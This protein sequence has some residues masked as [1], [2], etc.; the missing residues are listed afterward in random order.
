[1]GAWRDTPLAA[2][3]ELRLRLGLRRLRGRG[4]VPELV[5]KALSYLVL[6]PLGVVF[7]GLVGAGMYRAARSGRG[8]Q[9]DLPVSAVLFGVWQ[10]WTAV[11]MSL[12]EREGVDLRRF[13]V[14]PLAAGRVFTYGLVASVV[15]DP[16]ALFWCVLLA[17]AWGGAAVGRPGAWLLPLALALLLFAASVACSVVLLQEVSGRILRGKRTRE[18][19]IALLYVGL[20]MGGAAL[21]GLRGRIDL[22][23]AREVLG[24]VQWLA[25]PAA[26]GAGAARRLF[27]GEVA[28]ALPWLAG[29]A[30]AVAASGWAAY[31]LTLSAA[32]SG[33]AG[34]AASGS[35]GGAGWAGGWLPGLL[36]P[37]LEREVKHLARHPLPG[38]LLLVIPAMAGVVAWQAS[39]LI[40]AEAGEVLRALPLLGFALYTHLAT[41]VFWLNA[42][43]WD[44]GGARQHYLAPLDLGEVLAAK[45]L[46]TY[47]LAALLYLGCVLLTVALV[48]APPGWALLA[49]LALHAGVAPWL[50]GLG[51]LLSVLN[52]RVASATLQRSGNLPALSGLL[53]MAIV[54]GVAGLF[55]LPVLLAL[56]LDQAWILPGAWLALGA[57]GLALYRGTL[58]R[59]G[60]LLEARRELLLG[61]VTGDEA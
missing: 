18:V 52:P 36:G 27:S 28:A 40:P 57:A 58:P 4:G 42:F 23:R 43:G 21:A 37:L 9:V 17:G 53:G 11:A 24:L 46:A 59:M 14:Y 3:V 34:G 56:R 5:A 60:R 61:V 50:H 48:G 35:S 47:A 33:G 8:V 44:R 26:L 41:Q 32:T 19:A 29:Q 1:M 55:A 49:A 10:A 16:F 7:A 31:R 13:L 30:A 51:N 45:N 54:S 25:W 20:A 39:P 2:L 15:G 38:V 22:A 12:H 6:L